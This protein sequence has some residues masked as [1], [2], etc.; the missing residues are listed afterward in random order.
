[1][2]LKQNRKQNL[3]SST[4]ERSKCN[5]NSLNNQIITAFRVLFFVVIFDD[6]RI[7]NYEWPKVQK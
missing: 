4:W 2:Q 6:E 5:R 7:I 1:M 3:K